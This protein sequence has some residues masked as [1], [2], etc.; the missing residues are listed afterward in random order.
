M[1][2]QYE[3]A[4]SSN[5]ILITSTAGLIAPSDNIYVSSISISSING[6]PYPTVDDS[7]WSL[8][9][10][11]IFN[12][13]LGTGPLKYMV[14]VGTGANLNGTLSVLYTGG[15]T[16]GNS[17]HVSSNNN[18][19]YIKNLWD[20][21]NNGLAF[22][23]E[24]NQATCCGPRIYLSKSYNFQSSIVGDLG[25]I[26]FTGTAPNQSSILG[27]E[28][29]AQQTG[30][31]ST[32]VPTDIL[33][34]NGT[35]SV[36]NTNMIIKDSG[37][38]GIGT[39]TPAYKLD[40]LGGAVH[41]NPGS[42]KN[43]IFFSTAVSEGFAMTWNSISAGGINGQTE[44][45]SAKG[46]GAGGIDFFVGV[47]DNVAAIA[48]DLAVRIT[49]DKKMGVNNAAPE[50]TLQVGGTLSTNTIIDNTGS[51][52]AANQVLTAGTGGEVEWAAVV[53]PTTYIL[54]WPAAA[55]SINIPVGPGVAN[56][57]GMLGSINTNSNYL[58][59]LNFQLSAASS[60]GSPCFMTIVL[61]NSS[62]L[63][64]VNFTVFSITDTVLNNGGIG[65]I[66]TVAP[67]LYTGIYDTFYVILQAIGPAAVLGLTGYINNFTV[68][69]V[70]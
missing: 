51:S 48:G 56:F 30:S 36:S 2:G 53:Y 39:T 15:N 28:I 10:S 55:V 49:G 20:G 21:A 60:T 27:A 31:P 23:L 8:V 64:Q 59:T 4:I 44:I 40:V 3:H 14:G 22:H 61:Q 37:N 12:K 6:L 66:S 50:A 43:V 19:T 42:N 58:F 46:L 33:F 18:Y 26:K 32:F 70:P 17:F 38:V 13:N 25:A 34:I 5:R 47:A 65:L 57:P 67:V 69:Q 9:G 45:I 1:I 52:G 16:V 35:S 63:A 54:K 24:E 11:T 68:Q 41:F 29:T 62:T 7:L